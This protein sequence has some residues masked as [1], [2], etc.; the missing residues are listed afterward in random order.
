[1]KMM[2]RIVK[3]LEDFESLKIDSNRDIKRVTPM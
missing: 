1:M 2:M 3:L